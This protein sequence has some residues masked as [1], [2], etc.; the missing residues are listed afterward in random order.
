MRRLLLLVVAIVVY[1]SLY[2]ET[3]QRYLPG[4][5]PEITDSIVA[6]VMTAALWAA[7]PVVT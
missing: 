2:L 5:T 1:G 3:V 4:R 6:I 7:R